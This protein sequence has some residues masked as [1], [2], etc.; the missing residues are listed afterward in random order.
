M[1]ENEIKIVDLPPMRTVSFLGFSDSPE[2]DAI[3][4]AN[5]WL[6]SQGL[7]K[8]GAYRHFGFNNP[9]PSPGSQMYGYEVWILPK[10]GIPDDDQVEIKEFQG[11]LYAVTLCDNTD[12][13]ERDWLKL[14]AWCDS[15]RYHRGAHQWLEEIL[16]PPREINELS[17][18]LYLPIVS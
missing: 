1:H 2:I 5:A 14:A 12:S 3:T 6:K 9:P 10:E 4:S 17:F 18:H 13:I 11:G 15:S 16:D 7:L 8:K